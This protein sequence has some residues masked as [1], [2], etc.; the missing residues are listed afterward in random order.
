MRPER[1]SKLLLS[2]TQAKAKM[3]EYSVPIENHLNLPQDPAKLL[4]LTVGTLGD[5]AVK[6]I[7]NE[8][9]ESEILEKKK[10]LEFS[11]Y[12]FDS[13]FKTR[14][15]DSYDDY[16]L[17][18]G[19]SAYYLCDF[20][21]SSKVLINSLNT[22]YLDLK[23][24]GLEHFLFCLLRDS[25]NKKLKFKSKIYGD[26]L[27]D[28]SFLLDEF[29]ATG[30][31]EGEILKA[32]KHLRILVYHYGTDRQLLVVDLVC[33]ITKIKIN[34]SSWK[35]LPIYSGNENWSEII[36][37][38]SFVKEFWPAQHL[39]GKH[40]VFSGK[41]AIVQLP[42]SAGKTKAIDIIIRSSF[43]GER[44]ALVVVVTPFRALCSEVKNHFNQS[45]K[46]EDVT[47]NEIPDI[48]QN[49]FEL[50]E[51]L[52][53]KTILV[54][55]P[56]KLLYIIRKNKLMA[57]NIGL[58]IYD[59]GHQF[60]NGNRGVNY[61]LLLTELKAEL[62]INTQIILIS[63]V[64]SNAENIGNWLVEGRNEVITANRLPS[65]FRTIAFISWENNRFGTLE[66]VD[67]QN[68]M[69]NQFNV[70]MVVEEYELLLKGK[71]TRKRLFPDKRDNKTI[72]AYLSLKIVG[73][74][75]VALFNGKKVSV[76]STCEKILD[77]YNRGFD[78]KMPKEYSDVNEIQKISYL[79][80]CHFGEDDIYSRMAEMGILTHHGNTP[81]GVRLSVEFALK[82]NLAKFVIC[83][84]TLAQGVNLPIKYLIM[85]DI[86]Q[87]KDKLSVRDFQNL[88]GRAG[89]AG[90]HTEGSIIFSDPSI[91]D[92]RNKYKNYK[93]TQVVNLLDFTNTEPCLST[94]L[95]IFKPLKN[96]NGKHQINIDIIHFV[97]EYL[98]DPLEF[99]WNLSN[100]IVSENKDLN[101][102]VEGLYNQILQRI[103]II[104]AIES[105]LL[106]H[107]ENNTQDEIEALASKT[108]AYHLAD[109]QKKI[110]LIDLFSM[111]AV[112][113]IEK[114][115]DVTKRKVLG[116]NLF[117]LT[118]A[119]EIDKWVKDN[120]S[121]L[122]KD[123]VNVED[124]LKIIK[125][126]IIVNIQNKVFNSCNEKAVFTEIIS[127]WID[128]KSFAKILEFA[129]N[130]GMKII[131]AKRSKELR[132][133]D[134]VEICENAISYEGTLLLGAVAE[135]IKHMDSEKYN[136][137]IDNI[138]ILQ[139][140]MK[141]GLSSE[142]SIHL[143]ELG[144]TDRI[145]CNDINSN[146]KII[147]STKKK[148]IKYL[149][150]N[151]DTIIGILEKY[152]S[153]FKGVLNNY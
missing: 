57:K 124:L 13:Y 116:K 24:D 93:W 151:S 70:P 21:G 59:E 53:G 23:G 122:E 138:N 123:I 14:L 86:Y 7:N 42:T 98:N 153:Y 89:R 117:G 84:S 140:M 145:I 44:A 137:L 2:L 26:L 63:A 4:S 33:A 41:S 25:L 80:N 55:T 6:I 48:M 113:N 119:M 101:F 107:L 69:N 8:L 118:K 128:G 10:E 135:S 39:L 126:F 3:Y 45:F 43:L 148:V 108:F 91:Y 114:V 5:I 100:K 115:K 134:I 52:F 136:I 83:T 109:E 46:G 56:E 92:D 87:G 120:I 9:S 112:N 20:P 34:N 38:D 58:I 85:S 103:N 130:S 97:K 30:K 125:P 110:K 78:L 142:S 143:Y 82:E 68:P 12:Y 32:I 18:I 15:N 60:D 65:T 54:M 47:I 129:T 37:K 31:R 17:L 36:K 49:D 147:S 28:L 150:T 1:N 95:S 66:F 27:N 73:N 102:S 19:A 111:L 75:S 106:T 50:E 121:I 144:F 61:E 35:C 149:K 96:D 77:A 132:Q 90:M 152:P 133:D 79:Y 67:Q 40:G 16:L 72:A 11:A 146:I 74:G 94:M 71:E 22:L 99:N 131:T 62:N 29:F 64:V 105:F 51:I 76:R 104:S 139:K 88:I 81:I 141:Y 127:M